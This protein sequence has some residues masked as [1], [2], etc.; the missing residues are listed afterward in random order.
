MVNPPM[1][2]YAGR[3]QIA[4]RG[5]SYILPYPIGICQVKPRKF[6]EKAVKK[7]RKGMKTYC[8]FVETVV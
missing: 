7:E 4:R 5:C 2:K 1:E 3:P 8:N 6:L